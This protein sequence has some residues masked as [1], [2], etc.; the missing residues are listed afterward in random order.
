LEREEENPEIGT[1][2]EWIWGAAVTEAYLALGAYCGKPPIAGHTPAFSPLFISMT[3]IDN[4][5]RVLTAPFI[6][7]Y[8][9][10]WHYDF[11]AMNFEASYWVFLLDGLPFP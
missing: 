4:T 1:I 8:R 11:C 7:V 2:S 5:S 10:T 3:Y 9:I 6:T